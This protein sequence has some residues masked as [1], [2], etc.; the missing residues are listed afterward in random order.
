M[1]LGR[2]SATGCSGAGRCR[3]MAS[4]SWRGFRARTSSGLGSGAARGL[5]SND[6][7]AL[8]RMSRGG[9]PGYVW[10]RASGA[11]AARWA[12]GAR[13]V[14]GWLQA[15]MAGRWRIGVAAAGSRGRHGLLDCASERGA[16]GR[17]E[18]AGGRERRRGRRRL[19]L[20]EGARARLGSRGSRLNGPWAVRV[21]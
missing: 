13:S 11:R 21:S 16:R 10:S 2:C 19:Q 1:G 15:R 20:E 8:G 17:R 6:A 7:W 4:I 3:G 12:Q 14:S 9:C 18:E 5:A